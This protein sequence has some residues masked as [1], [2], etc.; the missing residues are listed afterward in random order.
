MEK[1]WKNNATIALNVL[2][3]KKEKIY[4][5]YVSKHSSNRAKQNILLMIPNIK[6]KLVLKKLSTLSRGK[7]SKPYGDFYCLNCLHCLRANNKFELHK[8][9]CENKGFF[10]IIMPSKDT[11]ILEFN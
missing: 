11:K 9:V 10:N 4:P 5:A 8:R 3:A 7:A 2:N 1:F 6:K